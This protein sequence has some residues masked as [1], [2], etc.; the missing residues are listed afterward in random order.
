MLHVCELRITVD[1]LDQEKKS[2]DWKKFRDNE[3]PMHM[4]E[5]EILKKN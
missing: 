5:I 4:N 3:I 2:R 1:I